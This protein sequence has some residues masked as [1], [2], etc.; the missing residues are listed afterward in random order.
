MTDRVRVAV[1]GSGIGRLHV[2]AY[3]SLPEHFEVVAI[4]DVDLARARA[5]AEAQ[6]VP[7]VLAD[8]HDLLRVNEV[9]VV[10]LCTPP[11]LH[12]EQTI[13]ALDAGHHVVCEKPLAGALADV[14]RVIAAAKQARGR[15]MPI[16]QYRFGHG[17]EKLRRLVEAGVAGP[18][19]LTT[20]ETAWRRRAAYYAVPW[21]GRWATELGGTIVSHAIHAHDLVGYVLGPIRSVYAR[22]ATRV[23][24]TETEDCVSAS[25]EMA[26]GSLCSLS[27]TTG[28]AAELSR[29]RFCFAHLSA[30]SNTEPYR[31]SSDPWTFTGDSPAAQEAIEA[32]L[33]AHVPRPEGFAGQ[34]LR[35]HEALRSGTEL[36]VT[37]IDARASIE[38]ITALYHAGRT[39][40]P[41]SL[42]L[43]P[44]HPLYAGWQP[45]SAAGS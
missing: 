41:V 17:I 29:H 7:R 36:P 12:V 35:F 10:D 15:V 8:Y 19:Y 43:G 3:R 38:L 42:P 31:N 27:V 18:A 34:F 6:E 14:D 33:R 13:A 32:T 1:V 24:A 45:R 4:C 44:E 40:R 28:S 11:Y 30:E 9:D 5:V 2:E 39:G 37:L 16:V 20:V 25:L 22:L 26:D 21:R 23:N